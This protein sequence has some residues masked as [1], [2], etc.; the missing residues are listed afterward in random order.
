MKIVKIKVSDY[1]NL[2]DFEIDLSGVGR[3]AIVVG[4]NGSGKSNFL[5]AV[6]LIARDLQGWNALGNQMF[7]YEVVFEIPSGKCTAKRVEGV[8][9]VQ[10]EGLPTG[11][12]PDFLQSVIAMYNGEFKRLLNCGYDLDGEYAIPKPLAWASSSSYIVAL[13]SFLCSKDFQMEIGNGGLRREYAKRVHYRMPVVD[14]V[15]VDPPDD[16]VDAFIRKLSEAPP[17]SEFGDR[18]LPFSEFA[19]L[20]NELAGNAPRPFFEQVVFV[21]GG[22]LLKNL[23]VDFE[24]E[25][26][27]FSSEDFSEG[28]KRIILIE[29]VLSK[30]C[31]ENRIVLL[32]EPDASVHESRKL[33]L[34]DHIKGYAK[35]GVLTILTTH[36]P[37][38]INHVDAQHLIGLKVE[39]GRTK[40]SYGRDMDVLGQLAGSR[41]DFFSKKPIMMFEGKSDVI[42]LK[43]VIKHFRDKVSGYEDLK[44]DTDFDYYIIGGTGNAKYVYKQFHALQMGRRIFIALDN[45][46]AGKNALEQLTKTDAED[47]EFL[48]LQ[49]VTDL[50]NMTSSGNCAFLIPRPAHISAAPWMVEDYL[51]KDFIQRWIDNRKQDFFCFHAV[52]NIKEQLKDDIGNE[53]CQFQDSDLLGFKPLVD[54]LM[55]LKAQ[56]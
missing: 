13:L 42:L 44:L 36:S 28:E 8:P 52:V 22:D 21:E 41:M 4:C 43:R 2:K 20:V 17:L 54:Y 48:P 27:C 9:N 53:G 37:A 6:S 26:E 15:P 45:D 12:R 18:E 40:V 3:L 7:C 29:Y 24:K 39:E 35:K 5:E 46:S 33:E 31:E 11:M 23:V 34:V 55:N 19:A 25:G 1:K 16:E 30:A 49:D 47:P 32:D 56:L 14:V 50:Q 51:P 38:I 10:W